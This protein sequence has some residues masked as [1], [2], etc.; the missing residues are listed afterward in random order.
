MHTPAKSM[1]INSAIG[2]C[3]VTAIPRAEPMIA[4]PRFDIDG[5]WAKSPAMSRNRD[6]GDSSA[7]R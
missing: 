4:A 3:S 2:R 1:N 7:V 6:F 5:R